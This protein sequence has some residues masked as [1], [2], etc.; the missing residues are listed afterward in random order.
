MPASDC[1]TTLLRRS[2]RLTCVTVKGTTY[3]GIC[4]R[5]TGAPQ[6]HW[7]GP[8]GDPCGA[9]IGWSCHREIIQDHGEISAGWKQPPSLVPCA[10]GAPSSSWGVVRS[11]R[12]SCSRLPREVLM[13]CGVW[14]SCV[15]KVMTLDLLSYA[16]HPQKEGV[17]LDLWKWLQCQFPAHSL[18]VVQ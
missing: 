9:G 13:M 17:V 18:H 5:T 10:V 2:C 14:T 6:K 1:H 11:Q 8:A 3:S 15:L 7:F 12:S 4:A 16:Q